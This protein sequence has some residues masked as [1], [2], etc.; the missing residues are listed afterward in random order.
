MNEEH[1]APCQKK[2]EK[3]ICQRR[4]RGH[5]IRIK[6]IQVRQCKWVVLYMFQCI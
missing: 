6:K 5:L 3:E 4:F 1:T 2:K